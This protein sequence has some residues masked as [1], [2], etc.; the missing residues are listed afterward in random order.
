MKEEVITTKCE[1]YLNKLE[2]FLK[3]TKD[4][5][6]GVINLFE[7]LKNIENRAANSIK[8]S[9]EKFTVK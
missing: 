2:T 5:N 4:K 1:K 6:K 8:Q 3:Y 9:L 7:D